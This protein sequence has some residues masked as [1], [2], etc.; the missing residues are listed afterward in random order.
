MRSILVAGLATL[1][2]V[3]SITFAKQK[4]AYPKIISG[5]DAGSPLRW[6]NPA[7]ETIARA[8]HQL[9]GKAFST[10]YNERTNKGQSWPE[11][12]KKFGSSSEALETTFKKFQKSFKEEVKAKEKKF[13]DASKLLKS[14][15][16][17]WKKKQKRS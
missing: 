5:A 4:S 12:A 7:D 14:E 8:M 17:A 10:I 6:T 2:L 15:E 13:S 16:K 11:I 3:S 9:T 1:L